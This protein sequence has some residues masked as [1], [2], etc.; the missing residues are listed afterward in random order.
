ML[1]FA[2]SFFNRRY[3]MKYLNTA[4]Y[5]FFEVR[6]YLERLRKIFKRKATELNLLGTIIITPEG[7]NCFISGLED[8][9]EVFK[10]FLEHVCEKKLT[11]KDSWSTHKP[12]N[13]MLVKV[14]KQIVP[15][16]DPD[17]DPNQSEGMHLHPRDFE[18]WIDQNK[19]MIILDTRN[20]FEY[21]IGSFK[22]ATHLQIENFR[23]FD[24]KLNSVPEE[25]KEKPIVM[26]CTGGIR[27][28]KA[29]P[30]MKK[31]GFKEVYQLDGGI[32]NYFEQVG[33]KHYQ[34]DCFVFDK[35]VALNSKLEETDTVEC[36]ACRHPVTPEEQKL[37]SYKYE[38][39]C[40]YCYNSPEKRTK[41]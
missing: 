39:Y 22:N 34:G 25:W 6:E 23:E 29:S 4:C 40:P 13:R 16:N 7:I 27:C 11:F 17:I 19:D 15:T 5:H 26:F 28:E 2:P 18:K 3:K 1:S 8:D 14:K 24:E 33:G 20:E 31:K 9:V 41:Y 12:F 10:V 30:I 21:Q 38:A 36:F 32:L 37:D 35:R